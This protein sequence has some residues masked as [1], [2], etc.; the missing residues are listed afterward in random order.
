MRVFTLNLN[1]VQNDEDNKEQEHVE[2]EMQKIEESKAEEMHLQSPVTENEKQPHLPRIH[3][4]LPINISGNS[5][6]WCRNNKQ[7]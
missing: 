4:L 3:E 5:K 2:I 7:T 1:T 6:E